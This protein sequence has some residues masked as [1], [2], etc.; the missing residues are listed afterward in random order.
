MLPE[1]C[2]VRTQWADT[3]KILR[4]LFGGSWLK[5]MFA[6]C[7]SDR[8]GFG[9]TVGDSAGVAV[10]RAVGAVEASVQFGTARA[11]A[12]IKLTPEETGITSLSPSKGWVSGSNRSN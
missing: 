9:D 7:R 4:V 3:V 1:P 12:K 2:R 6:E 8:H 11:W 10:S 5:V